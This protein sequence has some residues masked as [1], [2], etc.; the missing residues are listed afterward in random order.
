MRHQSCLSG[1]EPNGTPHQHS[2]AVERKR[3]PT[4]TNGLLARLPLNENRRLQSLLQTISLN[5]HCV[6]HHP[7]QAVNRVFFPNSRLC[8][9]IRVMADGQ[10]VEAAAIGAEG[11]VGLSPFFGYG[12]EAG[13]T[14]VE[15]P[16]AAQAMDVLCARALVGFQ[17][18]GTLAF[19]N[20]AATA[21]ILG[22]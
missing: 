6:V 1:P 17:K 20:L 14:I 11:L 13:E 19:Q 22:F 15:M 4:P 9:A 12:R 10:M 7:D 2:A 21:L 16:G 5:Q 8:S 18:E 3:G